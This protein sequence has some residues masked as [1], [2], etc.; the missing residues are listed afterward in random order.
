METLT[1]QMGFMDDEYQSNFFYLREN[2]VT[3]RLKRLDNGFRRK[4]KI[5]G[6]L[7]S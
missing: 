5:I 4:R 7:K 1:Y 6:L 2:I 3:K